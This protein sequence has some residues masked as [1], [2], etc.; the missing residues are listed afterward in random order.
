MW[1]KQEEEAS[2]L[3][4]ERPDSYHNNLDLFTRQLIEIQLNQ[5]YYIIYKQT[6]IKK[7]KM[8]YFLYVNQTRWFDLE[9]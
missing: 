6:I 1:K 7:F 4:I 8:I 3:L 5:M 2:F 9:Y